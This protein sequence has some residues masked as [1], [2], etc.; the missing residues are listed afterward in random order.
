MYVLKINAYIAFFTLSEIV[1][2]PLDNAK[3][4]LYNVNV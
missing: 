2:S 4:Q 1:W 3:T